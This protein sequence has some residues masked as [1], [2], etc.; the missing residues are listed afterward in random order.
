MPYLTNVVPI[1]KG[2]LLIMEITK[3]E[4][5]PNKAQTWKSS[6]DAG[7]RKDRGEPGGE[8]GAKRSKLGED[9]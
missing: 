8:G 3:K 2:D 1:A 9:F 6:L 5:E 4:K 7:K